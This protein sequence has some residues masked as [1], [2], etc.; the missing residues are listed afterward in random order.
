MFGVS[1]DE[2]LIYAQQNRAEWEAKGKERVKMYIQK[3]HEEF[4]LDGSGTDRM[5]HSVA[6]LLFTED[7]DQA[8]TREVEAVEMAPLP[9]TPKVVNPSP[10]KPASPPMKGGLSIK[11]GPGHR[12]V[13]RDY[14]QFL[15][16]GTNQ[17]SYTLSSSQYVTLPT[18][19]SSTAMASDSEE[20]QS[21]PY[22]D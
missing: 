5:N 16:G 14:R 21:Q 12:R 11:P 18:E 4:D 20:S 9:Q 22:F 1:S 19:T 7:N 10:S 6:S 13:L 8:P 3:F 15:A 17:L 2:Y